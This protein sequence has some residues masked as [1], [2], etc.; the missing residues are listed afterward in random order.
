MSRAAAGDEQIR[1]RRDQ[2]QAK[3]ARLQTR[4]ALAADIDV[5]LWEALRDCRRLL[6][7]EQGVPLT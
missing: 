3:T 7:E 1:L 6:A 5:A 2:P 4:S